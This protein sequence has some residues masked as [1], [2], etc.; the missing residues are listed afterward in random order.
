MNFEKKNKMNNEL[1]RRR[2]EQDSYAENYEVCT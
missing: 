2:Y 1:P